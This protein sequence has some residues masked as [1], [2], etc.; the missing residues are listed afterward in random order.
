MIG[1]EEV[2]SDIYILSLK[3]LACLIPYWMSAKEA[4]PANG[5]PEKA[6]GASEE[7]TK[8]LPLRNSLASR[9][10][11]SIASIIQYASGDQT[12]SRT[13]LVVDNSQ[14]QKI[15]RMASAPAM[16]SQNAYESPA[17][18]VAVVENILIPHTLKMC[19]SEEVSMEQQWV[20]LDEMIVL[21]KKL[22]VTTGKT[23]VKL[24]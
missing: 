1:L 23:K 7:T 3:G 10:R 24:L 21:W 5:K 20:L 4:L 16:K 17:T 8:S 6:K 22:S 13:S 19:N 15:R 12:A 18:P 14:E 11:S 2:D 9:S